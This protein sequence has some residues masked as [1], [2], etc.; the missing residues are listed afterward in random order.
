MNK[1]YI[2][3]FIFVVIIPVLT[4]LFC[5][6]N[7]ANR[8]EGVNEDFEYLKLFTLPLFQVLLFHFFLEGNKISKTA[9]V[10]LIG[11][12]CWGLLYVT[13]WDIIKTL[14]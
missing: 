6:Y 1:D 2:K 12:F 5:I 14:F 9:I 13:Q 11:I 3:S 4:G 10:I 7:I 8:A